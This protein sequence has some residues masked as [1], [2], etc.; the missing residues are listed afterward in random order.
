[1]KK[2]TAVLL[3]LC[4]SCL[5]FSQTDSSFRDKKTRF[6]FQAGINATEFLKQFV[7]FNN[8]T[9]P[10]T[11][12]FDFN[13]KAL[14]GFSSTPSLLV[15]PR[16]GYGYRNTHTY[17]NNSQQ[18]NE[19]SDDDRSRSLRIGLELQHI[20]S[21]RLVLLFGIDYIN[22]ISRQ[23]TVTSFPN[24]PFGTGRSEIVTSN[25]SFGYGPVIG[26]QFNINRRINLNTE[27]SFYMLESRGGTRSTSSNPNNVVNEVFTDSRSESITLPLFINCNFMF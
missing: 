8:N 10:T 5:V 12:P 26:V 9:L 15:G 7:V 6:H 20:V 4:F 2:T 27:A 13:L 17:T 18:D 23:S 24:P 22:S 14:A 25:K 1:M 3:F 11:S 16:F 21:R 19:R